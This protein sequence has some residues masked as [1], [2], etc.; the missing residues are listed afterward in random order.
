LKKIALIPARYASTRFP[1]KLM[2]PLGQKTVIL[3][4]YEATVNT[5]L[6]DDVAVV[7]DSEIIYQEINRNKGKA[8]MSKTGHEC[9]TDRI[10][11]ALLYFPHADVIVNVQGD[12]PFTQKEALRDLLQV[13]EAEKDIQV[14]SLMHVLQDQAALEN[15]NNVK[16]V[17]DKNNHALLFSRSVIP[18]S[19]DK[20]SNTVYYKHIGIYAF[21][22]EML[23]RFPSMPPTPLEQTEKLEGLRYLENGIKMKMVL[24]KEGVIGIDT[25]EDLVQARKFIS[26]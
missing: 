16:V 21:R 15:P 5:G 2:E 4:T 11:E 7:T 8:L 3:R 9:G 6:F 1:G 17:V 14:A 18:Y 19:R 12:E 26:L 24:A 20:E 22:R 13:F 10:A 25:P 23:L